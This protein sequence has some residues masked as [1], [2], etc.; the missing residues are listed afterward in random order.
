MRGILSCLHNFTTEICKFD[1]KTARGSA[2]RS[3]AYPGLKH[4]RMTRKGS[5]IMTY[6]QTIVEAGKA[7]GPFQQTW[8][9]IEPES[10]ARMRLQNRFHRVSTSPATPPRSCARH[11]CL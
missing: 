2:G 6:H 5:D 10:V 1:N 8:D 3:A 4:R 11:G 7:I 9:G